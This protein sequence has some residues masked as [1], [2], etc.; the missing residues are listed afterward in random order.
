MTSWDRSTGPVPRARRP[1]ALVGL[2]ALG[3]AGG[4]LVSFLLFGD[5]ASAALV[6]A[7]PHGIALRD[8]R[9]A[10]HRV[11]R[12]AQYPSRIVLPFVQPI[13]P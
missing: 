7:E 5:G 4:S 3:Y 1:A 6:T 10:T 12:S 2:V 13:V 8:F 9:A 11:Y